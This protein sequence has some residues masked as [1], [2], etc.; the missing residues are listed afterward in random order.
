MSRIDG[1]TSVTRAD[2]SFR[3]DGR[4]ALVTGAARGIGA[5]VAQEFASAGARLIVVDIDAAGAEDTAAA[6]QAGGGEA[7]AVA[8]D[9]R[10]IEQ[11]DAAVAQA[12]ARFGALDVLVANAGINIRKPFLDLDD[13]E[14]RQIVDTNLLG[15]LYSARAAG[16]H[17]IAHGG[18]RIISTTSISAVHGMVSRVVYCATKG[19]IAAFT[20]ALAMEWARHGIIVNAVGPGIIETPLLAGYLSEDPARRRRAEQEIPLGRLGQPD[21][22]VGTVRFLA[23]DAARYITGQ[24]I[25]VDGGLA[26]GDTWW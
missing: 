9:V 2:T 10:Q 8:A 5:A 12:L 6:I 15:V 21:D 25:Y 24:V 11:V 19:G 17:M 4:T 1:R 26:A 13:D 20:R 14:V 7:I 3:L 22:V 16:R 23:S 18:G